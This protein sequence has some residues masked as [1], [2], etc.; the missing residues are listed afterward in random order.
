MVQTSDKSKSFL[1]IWSRN[2][3]FLLNFLRMTLYSSPLH[4]VLTV[5]YYSRS[6]SRFSTPCKLPGCEV[7]S[8]NSIPRRSQPQLRFERHPRVVQ[9]RVTNRAL[10]R[11]P[12]LALT[13]N[14]TRIFATNSR[15]ERPINTLAN[16]RDWSLI[17]FVLTLYFV[18]EGILA[19]RRWHRWYHAITAMNR[20]RQLSFDSR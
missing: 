9:P 1:N 12:P 2:R 19:R 16:F 14:K 7:S 5:H 8:H 11:S 6:M 10:G 20:M 3:P 13:C 15:L 18:F 4:P 17:E